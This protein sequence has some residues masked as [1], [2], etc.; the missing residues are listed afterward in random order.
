MEGGGGKLPTIARIGES[1]GATRI[2][3]RDATATATMLIAITTTTTITT[4]N[5]GHSP[6]G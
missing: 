4:A 6:D 2:A 1:T 3:L 5:V